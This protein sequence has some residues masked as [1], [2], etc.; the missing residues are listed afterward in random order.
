MTDLFSASSAVLSPCRTYRY[1]LTRCWQP[2]GKQ[3]AFIML[4]PSTADE[5]V[6]DPTIRRC[7]GFAHR[8][9][10]ASLTVGN[11]FAYRATDPADL[12]RAENPIGPDNDRHLLA[13]ADDAEMV[14]CAWGAHGAHM[15]RGQAVRSLLRAPLWCLSR[16]KAGEPTHPLYLPG[17]LEPVPL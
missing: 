15:G 7:I 11:L 5:M 6:D 8:L 16:T 13:I 10:F 4:N 2:H 1:R 17:D 12:R 3:L 9:G 14:I